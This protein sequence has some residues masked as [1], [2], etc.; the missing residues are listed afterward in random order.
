MALERRVKSAALVKA[1]VRRVRKLGPMLF[2]V[3]KWLM[4]RTTDKIVRPSLPR[5]AYRLC[6]M[7]RHV[8]KKFRTLTACP[9]GHGS[10]Q[11]QK[12]VM[13]GNIG[14]SAFDRELRFIA[15]FDN[16]SKKSFVQP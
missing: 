10:L 6:L 15:R 4:T 1:L 7:L 12:T 16:M 2:A 11:T 8:V 14:S 13:L 9:N 3:F 5:N